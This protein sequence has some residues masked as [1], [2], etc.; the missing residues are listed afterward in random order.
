[1]FTEG[2]AAWHHSPSLTPIHKPHTAYPNI[3]LESD[4]DIVASGQKK[5]L[6]GPDGRVG[7]AGKLGYY[8]C[9]WPFKETAR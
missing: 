9:L 5:T 1:M 6:S 8:S 3:C 4:R 2:A 7:T